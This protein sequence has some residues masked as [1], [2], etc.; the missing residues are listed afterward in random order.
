VKDL[1]FLNNTDPAGGTET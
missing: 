1:N